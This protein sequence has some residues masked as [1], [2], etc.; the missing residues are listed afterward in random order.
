MR[1]R[2]GWLEV[3]KNTASLSTKQMQGTEKLSQSGPDKI[4]ESLCPAAFPPQS[5]QYSHQIIL[6]LKP[7]QVR[8][9]FSF[10]TFIFQ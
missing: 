10:K 5:V 2:I 3:L 6:Q 9:G 7:P 1:Y 8:K 4:S